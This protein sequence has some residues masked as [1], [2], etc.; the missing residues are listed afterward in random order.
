MRLQTGLVSFLSRDEFWALGQLDGKDPFHLGPQFL[1][2]IL[3]LETRMV[4]WKGNLLSDRSNREKWSTLKGTP[5]KGGPVSKL[6]R[7]D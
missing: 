3:V 1:A 5:L 2:E 6:F 4:E 7:V